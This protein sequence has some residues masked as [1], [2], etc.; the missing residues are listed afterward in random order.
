MVMPLF[1]T[2]SAMDASTAV[3]LGVSVP[4]ADSGGTRH[5]AGGRANVACFAP[6]VS[7]LEI[8][9]C[10]PGGEWRVQALPN[11]TGGV[12]HGI[13]EDLPYGSRYGFRPAPDGQ[14]LPLA[15]PTRDVKEP[16]NQPLLLDPYGN[17]IDQHD[18]VLTSVRTAAGFDWGTDERLRLPWRITIIYEAHV[19]GQSVL[20]PDVP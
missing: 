16:G 15:V 7:S 3:P 9:Y 17:G 2:T 18:G 12:H 19:R 10:P 13:V 5:H 6:A 4:H 20:H 1:D 8:V 14:S 11:T